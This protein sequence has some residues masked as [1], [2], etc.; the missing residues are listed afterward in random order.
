MPG[1]ERGETGI[2]VSP[3]GENASREY[4]R[5]PLKRVTKAKHRQSSEDRYWDKLQHPVYVRHPAAVTHINFN[6]VAPHNFA[7]SASTAV[8]LYEPRST[9]VKK[10]ISRFKDIAYSACYRGD[11][12]LLAAGGESGMVQIFELQTRAIL[13]QYKKSTGGHTKAVQA[14]AW[15]GSI[16]GQATTLGSAS[17]DNLVKLWDLGNQETPTNTFEGHTDYARCI[18]PLAS[19]DGNMFVSG[20]YDH[21][22]RCWDARTGGQTVQFD[23]GQPVE[24][25]L[26]YHNGA[27]VV[28]AGGQVIKVWDVAAGKLLHSFS[29]HQKAITCLAYDGSSSRLISGSLDGFVKM[30]NVQNYEVVYSL[31]MSAPVMSV[32]MAPDNKC[33]AIGLSDG[34]LAVRHRREARNAFQPR[35]RMP[36]PGSFGYQMRGKNELPETDALVVGAAKKTKLRPYDKLLKSFQFQAAV[37]LVLQDGDPVVVVSLLEEIAARSLLPV[38]LSGRNEEKLAPVLEF[39]MRHIVNPH[40]APLLV[41]VANHLLDMYTAVLGQ[42]EVIDELFVKLQVKV[43]SELKLQ[44]ELTTVSGMLEMILASMPAGDELDLEESSEDEDEDEETAE[45]MDDEE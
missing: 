25:V 19:N 14:V 12:K 35:K 41:D 32:A 4:H 10:R 31:K 11:G 20:S 43:N 39:L 3:A 8:V 24:S 7:V 36:R 1:R 42:S 18:C 9:E 5:V 6:P 13:R 23:H 15:G 26:S 33:L 16:N 22:V 29:N 45:M 27:L 30:Y 38:A 21:S 40:Y 34:T 2:M 28:S 37:D 17:D 44:R